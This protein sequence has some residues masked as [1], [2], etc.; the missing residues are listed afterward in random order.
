MPVETAVPGGTTKKALA[1]LAANLRHVV[2]LHFP[3]F[4]VMYDGVTDGSL[5]CFKFFEIKWGLGAFLWTG[6]TNKTDKDNDD[7]DDS[8]S[9]ATGNGSAKPC[10]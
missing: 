4:Q 6:L 3:K 1:Q 9:V 10:L 2:C 8:P 5:N 7:K